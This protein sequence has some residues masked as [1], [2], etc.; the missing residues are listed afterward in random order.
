MK[1]AI[2]TKPTIYKLILIEDE[3]GIDLIRVI[4]H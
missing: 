3:T 1:T 4:K 2:Q